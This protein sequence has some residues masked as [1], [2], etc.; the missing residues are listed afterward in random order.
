MLVTGLMHVLSCFLK[1][2]PQK[3]S[4]SQTSET[5]PSLCV[6]L[7]LSRLCF[8]CVSFVSTLLSPGLGSE[9]DRSWP[10]PFHILY[11]R[12]YLENEFKMALGWEE[13]EYM[14]VLDELLF[15]LRFLNEIHAEKLAQE[16]GI[17]VTL[18]LD[19]KSLCMT[20]PFV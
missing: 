1:L 7:F 2:L 8:A 18:R 13:K 5:S 15:P 3:G 6:L 14:S 10:K 12:V 11:L 17:S 9:V 4:S 20:I 19:P 16:R